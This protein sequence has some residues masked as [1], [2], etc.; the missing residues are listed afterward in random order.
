MDRRFSSP[1]CLFRHSSG[2]HSATPDHELCQER[3]DDRLGDATGYKPQSGNTIGKIVD[4]LVHIGRWHPHAVA[5]AVG[6]IVVWASFHFIR[7][8]EAFAILLALVVATGVVALARI[9]VETVGDIASIA[10]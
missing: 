5:V 10:N 6:T 7:P 3:R 8:L 1:R 2:G 9:D 4:W